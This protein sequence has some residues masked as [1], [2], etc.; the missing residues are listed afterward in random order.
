L[1]RL[2]AFGAQLVA[3]KEVDRAPEAL[4]ERVLSILSSIGPNNA[5]DLS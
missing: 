3:P 5:F 2:E 1:E 4:E